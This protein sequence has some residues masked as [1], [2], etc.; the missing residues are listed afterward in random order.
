MPVKLECDVVLDL[1]IGRLDSASRTITMIDG[2]KSC[3]SARAHIQLA[4]DVAQ[5][6]FHSPHAED[7]GLGDIFVGQTLG[8]QVQ[9]LLLALG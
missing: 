2:P 3:L 5:M 8:Q 7:K 6:C 1:V 4:K 9:Y